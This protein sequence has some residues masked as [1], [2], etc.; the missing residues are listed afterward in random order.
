MQTEQEM[1]FSGPE[2]F[3]IPEI[4]GED[5]PPFEAELPTK[6]PEPQSK[7]LDPKKWYFIQFGPRASQQEPQEPVV[8]INGSL[9][10]FKRGVR[11]CVP[12]EVLQVLDCAKPPMGELREN[13]RTGRQEMSY[14]Y[15]FR[16]PYQLLGSCNRDVAEKW[17]RTH[18]DRHAPKVIRKETRKGSAGKNKKG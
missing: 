10:R 2:Q 3:Q 6:E 16:V 18:L 11:H 1:D 17:Y 14:E 15:R 4:S 12:W 7:M 5:M 13:P 9:W 8:G